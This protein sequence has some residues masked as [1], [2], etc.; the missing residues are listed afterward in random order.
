VT[1]IDIWRV[2][3]DTMW[4]R[5]RAQQRGERGD[6]TQTVI[7]IAVFAA[8]AIAICAIIVNKFTSK[9]QSIPTG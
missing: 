1:E 5:T 4:R 9:A 8:A 7:I 3:L 6:I 2:W